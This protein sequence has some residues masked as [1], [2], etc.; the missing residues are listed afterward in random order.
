MR[1]LACSTTAF[2][3]ASSLEF[4]GVTAKSLT[5]SMQQSR[6]RF[7]H[8]L[9][10]IFLWGGDYFCFVWFLAKKQVI[11]KSNCQLYTSLLLAY[12]QDLYSAS[13]R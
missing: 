10:S 7:G 1:I 9:E 8:N 4:H 6:E 5:L 13:Q 11:I 2:S 12:I 3:E